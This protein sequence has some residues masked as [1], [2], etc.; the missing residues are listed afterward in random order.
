MTGNYNKISYCT[1]ALV[2]LVS[3]DPS[4][5]FHILAEPSVDD[6]TKNFESKLHEKGTS[7]VSGSKIKEMNLGSSSCKKK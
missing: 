3:G 2:K 5:M 6:E 1:E 7:T 4:S